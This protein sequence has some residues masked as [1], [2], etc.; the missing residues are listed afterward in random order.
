M[1]RLGFAAGYFKKQKYLGTKHTFSCTHS[2]VIQSYCHL[3]SWKLQQTGSRG[4]GAER[5]R[6]NFCP[7]FTVF[8]RAITAYQR[9]KCVYLGGHEGVGYMYLKFHCSISAEE[10][11]SFNCPGRFHFLVT[12]RLTELSPHKLKHTM[13]KNFCI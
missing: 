5:R 11:Y 9:F 8:V 1:T 7:S 12:L 2:S 3:M 6:E 4:D 13:Y 10:M